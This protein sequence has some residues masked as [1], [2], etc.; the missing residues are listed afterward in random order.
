MQKRTL[1][2]YQHSFDDLNNKLA[3]IDKSKDI[4]NQVKTQLVEDRKKGIDVVASDAIIN[5][6][7]LLISS[8]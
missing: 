2:T 7:T 3:D 4:L 6:I 5:Q 1:Q 8:L